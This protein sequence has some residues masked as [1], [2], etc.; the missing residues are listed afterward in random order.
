V[1]WRR[2]THPFC[3][4]L[5]P[6]KV[7]FDYLLTH[8]RRLGF[9][10]LQPISSS[11][12]SKMLLAEEEVSPSKLY[13]LRIKADR[14]SL[15]EQVQLAGRGRRKEYGKGR[16]AGKTI[17]KIVEEIRAFLYTKKKCCSLQP[18]VREFTCNQFQYPA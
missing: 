10:A 3:A 1:D 15:T 9:L 7:E 17:R 14:L 11:C 2:V 5:V 4:C 6:S 16:L 18:T 12:G 8:Y 13:S